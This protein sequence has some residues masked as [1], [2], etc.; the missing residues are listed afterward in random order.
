MLL[1]VTRDAGRMRSG[2]E[3]ASAG[4]PEKLKNGTPL[5]ERLPFQSAVEARPFSV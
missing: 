3:R 2:S 1:S 5:K 4:I